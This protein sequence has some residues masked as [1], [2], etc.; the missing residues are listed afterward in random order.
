MTTIQV[1]PVF[2]IKLNHIFPGWNQAHGA[3]MQVL[4]GWIQALPGKIQDDAV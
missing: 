3:Q 2:A 4:P 1:L